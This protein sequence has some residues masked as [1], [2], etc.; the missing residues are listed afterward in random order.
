MQLAIVYDLLSQLWLE[1]L[2]LIRLQALVNSE[3]GQVIESLG[4]SM[5]EQGT[6]DIANQLSSDYDQ[7]FK[8]SEEGVSPVQ[9]TWNTN[10]DTPNAPSHEARS[11]SASSCEEFY[12]TT[13]EYQPP[14]ITPDHLAVQFNFL[15]YLF[16]AAAEEN[17][18][19]AHV[20]IA[21]EFYATHLGWT[22]PLL[23]TVKKRANTDFYRGLARITEVFL[24]PV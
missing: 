14:E 9:S 15:A 1:P 16:H 13:P 24:Q 3:L 23:E 5:P 6:E 19:G 22:A 10:P 12:R 7:L 17:Q 18:T 20:E 11:N 8:D 2:S 4:G 21:T